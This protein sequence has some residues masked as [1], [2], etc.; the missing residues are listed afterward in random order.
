MIRSLAITFFIL[1]HITTLAQDTHFSQISQTPLFFNP[2]QTGAMPESFRASM[3]YRSQ[4]SSISS[5]FV[6]YALSADCRIVP[7]NWKTKHL[8][9]GITLLND[10]AGDLSLKRFKGDLTVAYHQLINS[11]NVLSGGLHVGFMQS[12]ID[13]SNAQWDTQYDGMGFNASLASGEEA[14]YPAFVTMDVGAGISWKLISSKKNRVGTE[15]DFFQFGASASHLSQ[16]DFSF[17]DN[18]QEKYYRRYVVQ[19]NA[20]I[21]LGGGY[22][23]LVPAVL[24]QLKGK[25]Q[26]IILGAQVF[27]A[28]KQQQISNTHFEI[29]YG[30]HWRFMRES[31]IP[32]IYVNYKTLQFG[33][34]Y[35]LNVSS[36]K[37]ASSN[38]GGIEFSLKFKMQRA[39]AVPSLNG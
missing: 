20:A 30:I 12:S 27:H 10:A 34:S 3:H 8:G 22:T 2:S 1:R 23:T 29:G 38:R 31:F 16:P 35:D 21:Q 6:S 28:H 19:S 18:A 9:V 37:N 11:R 36:L 5:P 24:Y 14:S 4:W 32:S 13:M 15:A 25:E 17:V 7:S 39:S 26:E 33:L